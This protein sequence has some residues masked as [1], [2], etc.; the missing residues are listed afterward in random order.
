MNEDAIRFTT[1]FQA[2][3]LAFLTGWLLV[4]GKSLIL[5][6]FAAVIAVYVL[7]MA[8]DAL[9]KLPLL[10]R[11]PSLI[12][13]ILVVAAFTLCLVGLGLVV[14][15][16]VDELI[17][18]A[19]TYKANLDTVAAQLAGLVGF[20]SLPSWEQIRTAI[21]PNLDLKELLT[22][23]LGSVTSLGSG[24][25][26]VVVYAVFLIAERGNVG[27]KLAAAFPEGNRA[28]RMTRLFNDIN[29]RIAEYLAAKT[30]INAILGAVSYVIMLVMGLDFALF[31]AL[32]IAVSN[33]IPYVGTVAILFPILLSLAQF[34]SLT[35]TLIVAALLALAQF[36]S[37]NVLEPKMFSRQLNLSPFV[38]VVALSLWSALWGLPG[39]ILA[40]PITSMLAIIFAAFP[41]T[42]FLA[43]LLAERV[44][45]L[46]E[47]KPPNL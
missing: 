17:I 16:T 14:S 26:L 45:G 29:R 46:D 47:P 1:I 25:F 3:V 38:V 18:A 15:A 2:L 7:L 44:D 37:D 6:I 5:P 10:D 12:R 31:W 22:D 34:G 33:Y 21:I 20:E 8:A 13:R 32:L 9:G 43:V 40:I 35:T 30:L 27:E 23:I 24:I 41:T 19:P 11:L 36:L 39:A 4:I 28:E 42:R